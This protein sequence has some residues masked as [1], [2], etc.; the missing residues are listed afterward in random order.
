M[1]FFPKKIGRKSFA[2]LFGF[3]S[4]SLL[5]FGAG[6]RIYLT[7]HQKMND[8]DL[9]L[10][11]NDLDRVLIFSFWALLFLGTVFF[12]VFLRHFLS[13]LKVLIEKSTQMRKGQF[14]RKNFEPIGDNFGAVSYTH[15]T[16]PTKA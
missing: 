7:R 3:Y 9:A 8:V 5:S 15:L 13:P 11:F 1:T 12:F 16:L 14:R 6:L 2:W 4:L 10:F